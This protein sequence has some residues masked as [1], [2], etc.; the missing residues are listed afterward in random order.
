LA[1]I[2]DSTILANVGTAVF[3]MV[4]TGLSFFF[5]PVI[6]SARPPRGVWG[7][8][9]VKRIACVS[10]VQITHRPLYMCEG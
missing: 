6:L 2:I 3:M 9:V 8:P 4:M 5:N 1:E 10:P 7:E